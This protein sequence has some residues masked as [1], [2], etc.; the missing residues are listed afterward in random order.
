MLDDS[1]AS[2]QGVCASRGASAATHECSVDAPRAT[3]R[4]TRVP[5]DLSIAVKMVDAAGRPLRGVLRVDQ[6]GQQLHLATAADSTGAARINNIPPGRYVVSASRVGYRHL[7]DT[8]A[9]T[10]GDRWIGA[11]VLPVQPA[12]VSDGCG[13]VRGRP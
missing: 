7:I 3:S 6:L 2:A 5:G 11:I 8:L 12:N 10:P 4:W 1:P 13:F 9:M